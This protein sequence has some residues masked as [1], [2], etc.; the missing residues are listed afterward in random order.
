MKK[1][2]IALFIL[3]MTSLQA[4]RGINGQ[5]DY[6]FDFGGIILYL[7]DDF[8]YR[9]INYTDT[10][11]SIDRGA[12]ELK[13]DT[14]IFNS[15]LTSS[16]KTNRKITIGYSYNLTESPKDSLKLLITNYSNFDIYNSEIFYNNKVIKK[17]D[18][19]KKDSTVKY[20]FTIKNIKSLDEIKLRVNNTK[21]KCVGSDFV[22]FYVNTDNQVKYEPIPVKM[23]L[24]DNKIY[25]ITNK[26]QLSKTY[27]TKK[28]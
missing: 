3:K 25:L 14:I 18:T 16:E 22:H 4:Q 2:L 7:K 5:F 1:L 9:F 8:S 13:N 17:V 24:K 6:S 28:E 23:L 15:S 19:I 11:K 21:K 26:K 10:S 27:L 20:L 12:Y